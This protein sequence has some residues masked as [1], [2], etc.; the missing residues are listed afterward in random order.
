MAHGVH[1]N[2]KPFLDFHTHAEEEGV[3]SGPDGFLQEHIVVT[4]A[5]NQIHL[6]CMFCGIDATVDEVEA[7]FDPSG[8]L[9]VVGHTHTDHH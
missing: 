9:N 8:E 7:G 4:S 1:R 5:G 3:M 2:F 6:M